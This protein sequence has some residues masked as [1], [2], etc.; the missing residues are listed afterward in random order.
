MFGATQ[1]DLDYWISSPQPLKSTGKGIQG[2]RHCEAEKGLIPDVGCVDILEV[3]LALVQAS[4][5]LH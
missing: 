1:T 3:R 4:L 2:L 5:A